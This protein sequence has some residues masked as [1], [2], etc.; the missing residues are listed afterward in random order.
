LKR[1]CVHLGTRDAFRFSLCYSETMNKFSVY[2]PLTGKREALLSYFLSGANFL[3]KFENYVSTT[4]CDV[5]AT[6]EDVSGVGGGLAARLMLSGE[7]ERDMEVHSADDVYEVRDE[8]NDL[9]GWEVVVYESFY[10]DNM[11]FDYDLL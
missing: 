4:E 8:E 7:R 3:Y 1:F 2:V 5:S 9:L 10:D 6:E 11:V